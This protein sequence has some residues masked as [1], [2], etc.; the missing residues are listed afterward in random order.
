MKFEDEVSQDD[1][2]WTE[3]DLPYRSSRGS[4]WRWFDRS[5]GTLMKQHR[6]PRTF[7]ETLNVNCETMTL[8]T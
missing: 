3:E 7:P 5:A 8:N 2:R 4:R 6:L 1:D